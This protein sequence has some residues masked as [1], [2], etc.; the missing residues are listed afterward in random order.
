MCMKPK[1]SIIVSSATLV[2]DESDVSSDCCKK[3]VIF[4]PHCVT[5][6][7]LILDE[8]ICRD[9]LLPP[10][11]FICCLQ[12]P[13]LSTNQIHNASPR[14]WEVAVPYYLNSLTIPHFIDMKV[15]NQHRERVQAGLWKSWNDMSWVF[16]S[17]F[18]VESTI[19][20]AKL[21]D[22]LLALFLSL[23]R[24][25]SLASW[26]WKGGENLSIAWITSFAA[27]VDTTTI[28]IVSLANPARRRLDKSTTHHRHH[29]TASAFNW[30]NIEMWMYNSSVAARR[31]H[32]D[33]V[34]SP[35][36]TRAAAE[37]RV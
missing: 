25:L 1:R 13:V 22:C 12:T 11:D 9:F 30:V 36:M 6:N 29:I 21:T 17:F 18:I 5:Q 32:H 20:S 19:Y 4:P 31:H 10:S 33:K 28:S 37:Q 15:I 3:V 7:F 8:E 24:T 34:K 27:A 26:Q 14:R 16:L 2:Y 23:H 35:T